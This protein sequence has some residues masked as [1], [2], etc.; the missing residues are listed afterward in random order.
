ME[1]NQNMTNGKPL[2]LLF[3]FALPLMFGNI[4]QQLYTVVDTAIVGNGVGMEALAALGTVDW[5]NWMLLGIAQGF[6]QGFSVR[7]SQKY[8][9]AD[10][11]G[12]KKAIGMAAR[13]SVV[14]ALVCVILSQAFLPLFLRFLHVP[15]ELCGMAE[16]YTRIL[17]GG[18]P[19]VVF[20]NF[21]SSV[22][23]AVGDSKTPLKAMIVAS[24]T[25]IVLDLLA[26][27]VLKWGIAGAAI[28]TVLSQCLSGF[29]CALKIWKTPELH[30][31][32][33][34]IKADGLLER[35]LIGIGTPVAA[36]NIIISI[37]GM[38]VQMIVNGFGMSFIAGFTATNKLYG[39][40][41]I[42]AISYGYA[43]TTYVG[44][45]YG[46]L[47]RQRIKSG[48]RAAVILSMITS[49]LIAVCMLLFGR[50]V[51]MLFISSENPEL[52][53]A[54]GDTAYFY[55]CIMSVFLPVLYLLYVYRSALQGMGNTMVAMVS[56]IIEFVLRVG[57]A[58]VIGMTGYETGILA[59]E[60][61]AWF[62]AA[63]FLMVEYYISVAKMMQRE[64]KPDI[65]G[66][67]LERG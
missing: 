36:Q 60:P 54:A 32:K 23:R 67:I 45:N 21:C 59:A 2:K 42:A 53:T 10:K 57:V 4:F 40:L 29:L 7:I 30:F 33:E 44:Q 28:A 11:N 22:L 49:V 63:V 17:F 16:L 3:F 12:V 9:E 5:L 56:G 51:T 65:R 26:V 52:V 18:L 1:E 31:G 64:E 50:A 8:G 15:V 43:V 46:A 37:G 39:I 35:K 66:D 25:N 24:F 14:I 34:H 13:L 62:G 47:E 19:A 20:Y 58:C 55:L 38:A 27:F 6:T 61:V 48:I 41:E